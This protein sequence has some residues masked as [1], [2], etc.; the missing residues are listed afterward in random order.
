MFFFFFSKTRRLCDIFN[1]LINHCLFLEGES[2]VE[3]SFLLSEWRDKLFLLEK[4]FKFHGLISHPTRVKEE[5]QIIF[6]YMLDLVYFWTVSNFGFHF[7]NLLSLFVLGKFVCLSLFFRCGRSVEGCQHWMC[8][9]RI[10]ILGRDRFST[11]RLRHG[12]ARGH[13]SGARKCSL[14]SINHYLF[15]SV[16]Q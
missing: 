3:Y 2:Q 7:H 11:P 8:S 5:R 4:E 16:H 6:N 15:H 14:I 1:T 12:Q 10:R 9:V 13:P